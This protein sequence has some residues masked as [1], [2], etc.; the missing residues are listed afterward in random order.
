[1]PNK[2]ELHEQ[3]E[4]LTKERNALQAK[5]DKLVEENTSNNQPFTAF[6]EWLLARPGIYEDTTFDEIL[7]EMRATLDD[8]DSTEQQ[9]LNY[10]ID[11]YDSITQQEKK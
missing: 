5:A 7:F 6:I 3:I 10:F 9:A 4:Q 11:L 2:T 1:M 8:H